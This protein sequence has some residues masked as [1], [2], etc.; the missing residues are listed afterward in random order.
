[1]MMG[2]AKNKTR[3]AMLH[4]LDGHLKRNFSTDPLEGGGVGADPF[5]LF[6]INIM[7]AGWTEHRKTNA[8]ISR[9][10]IYVTQTY[11]HLFKPTFTQ[12]DICSNSEAFLANK[13][14]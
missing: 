7:H 8:L 10:Y 11:T 3:S 1:M 2:F 6:L 12:S 9:V 4:V 5:V 14:K 13:D